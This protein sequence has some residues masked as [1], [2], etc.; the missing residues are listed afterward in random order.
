[1]NIS[2]LQ[3]I[4]LMPNQI[5]QK[6]NSRIAPRDLKEPRRLLLSLNSRLLRRGTHLLLYSP[7]RLSDRPSPILN[8]L[9]N[10]SLRK[11]RIKRRRG[12]RLLNLLAQ[13]LLWLRWTHKCNNKQKQRQETWW[14]RLL[15]WINS[16]KA[17]SRVMRRRMTLVMNLRQIQPISLS[18]R[19]SLLKMLINSRGNSKMRRNTSAPITIIHIILP[20]NPYMSKRAPSNHQLKRSKNLTRYKLKIQIMKHHI[21]NNMIILR[22]NH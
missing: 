21:S 13:Y 9:F 2:W 4:K 3:M 5:I 12:L 17:S 14:H 10:S 11:I 20:P 7:F 1:M 6:I 16:C 19:T 18:L 22:H 8:L 15:L